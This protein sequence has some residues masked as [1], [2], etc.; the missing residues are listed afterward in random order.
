[1]STTYKQNNDGKLELVT[2]AIF[3]LILSAFVVFI[4]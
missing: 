4:A 2:L 3:F 1:M